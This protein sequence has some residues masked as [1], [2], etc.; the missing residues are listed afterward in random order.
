MY[1]HTVS[2]HDALPICRA[3]ISGAQ[4]LLENALPGRDTLAVAGTHGK[5][6]T[7]T[8]LAF[9]LQAA[10]RE[11]GFLISGVA[12]DFG[13]SARIGG[14]REF[15]VEADDYDTAF[16]AQSSKFVHHRPPV[17]ILGNPEFDHAT[18]IDAVYASQR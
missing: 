14:G 11:P 4:W 10:G 15:V 7:T 5:T 8:S 12:E 3:C 13:V 17:E 9:L 6:R 2:L 18:I 16:F 1:C